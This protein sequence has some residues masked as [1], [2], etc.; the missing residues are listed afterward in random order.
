MK[1][2]QSTIVKEYKFDNPP[3]TRI[4]YIIDDCIRD[5]YHKFFHTFDHICEYNLNFT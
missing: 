2:N 5:C 1:E 3:I 4:D